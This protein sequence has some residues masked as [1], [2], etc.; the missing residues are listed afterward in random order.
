MQ[1]DFLIVFLGTI[2]ALAIRPT[3]MSLF[4]SRQAA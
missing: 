1:R 4:S 2:V 3:V